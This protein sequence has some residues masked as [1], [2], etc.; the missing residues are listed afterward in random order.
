MSVSTTRAP[1]S[2]STLTVAWPM[3]PAAPV[4]M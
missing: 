2:N 4:T 1:S 3:P